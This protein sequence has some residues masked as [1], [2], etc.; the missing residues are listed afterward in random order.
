[1][2][3]RLEQVILACLA[4]KPEDRPSSAAAVERMLAA[5]DVDPWTNEQAAEWW[6]AARPSA[7][8]PPGSADRTMTSA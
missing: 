5:A 8:T 3:P 4:K 6:A 7:T 1:V 2:P